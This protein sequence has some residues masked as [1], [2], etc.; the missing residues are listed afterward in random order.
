MTKVLVRLRAGELRNPEKVG[1]FILGTARNTAR[2]S[3][4]RSGRHRALASA[5][6]RERCGYT[7][8]PEARETERLAAALAQLRERERSVVL[9]TFADGLNAK[10]IG[11]SFALKAGH[12]RVIRH[13]ALA[14][15]GELLGVDELTEG[16]ER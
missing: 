13:R 3:R 12:V 2:E 4:R 10:E 9:L 11:A 16:E 1:S 8:A 14:R 15:L 6:E 7:E 5:V